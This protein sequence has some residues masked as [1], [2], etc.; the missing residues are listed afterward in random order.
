MGKLILILMVAVIISG[1]GADWFPAQPESTAPVVSKEPA[2]AF[3]SSERNPVTR[4][5]FTTTVGG[6]FQMYTSTPFASKEPITLETTKTA[7][8]V[9]GR[10]L[11][12]AAKSWDVKL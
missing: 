1:C 12:G 11:I 2:G 10:K 5:W 9:T 4:E 3:L 6:V 8:K 7:I